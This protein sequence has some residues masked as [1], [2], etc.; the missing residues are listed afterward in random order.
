MADCPTC[1]LPMVWSE[2]HERVWCAVYGDHRPTVNQTN[3][4]RRRWLQVVPDEPD[5]RTA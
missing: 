5:E 1:G 4:M 2:D 3:V